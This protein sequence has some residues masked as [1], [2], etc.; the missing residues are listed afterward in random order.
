V[1]NVGGIVIYGD[2]ASIYDRLM[3]DVEYS[4]W[5]DYIEAIFKKYNK[6]PQTVVDLGCGT[7][8]MCI[9]LTKRGYEMIGIDLSVDMLSCARDKSEREHCDILFLNQDIAKFELY[10]TVDAAISIMDSVN[11]LT[12]KSDLNSFFKLVYNYLNPEGLLIFDINTEYKLKNILG[13]NTYY[14]IDDDVSYIWCNNYDRKKKICQFDLTF[15]VKENELYRRYDETHFERAYSVDEI[16]KSLNKS[17]L[18]LLAICNELSFSPPVKNS[19]R[20]F[21]ICQ[22]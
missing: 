14:E 4:K 10:G 18:K 11:Y 21:F 12:L 22:K 16:K 17:G 2:F 3:Y 15:F 19:E 6:K 9:E 8:S 20:L 7:G 1:F 5:A 13:N